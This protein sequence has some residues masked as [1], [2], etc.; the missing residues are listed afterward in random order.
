MSSH[1]QRLTSA[2]DTRLAVVVNVTANLRAQLYELNR[3]RERVRKAEL[4][5][6]IAAGKAQKKN[7]PSAALTHNQLKPPPNRP[8][9][10]RSVFPT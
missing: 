10:R 5:P 7:S 4:A 8:E 2:I 6:A 3:L 1:Q 9:N